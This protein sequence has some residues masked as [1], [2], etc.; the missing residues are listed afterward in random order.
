[1][2]KALLS[3]VI[4]LVCNT[5]YADLLGVEDAQMIVL[6]LKQLQEL[7]NHSTLAIFA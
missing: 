3:L 5:A 7:Q 2:R 1:M 4:I 6:A